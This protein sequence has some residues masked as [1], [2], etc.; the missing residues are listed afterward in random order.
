[1]FGMLIPLL[2]FYMAFEAYHTA[3]KRL[4]GEPVDEFSGLFPVG[5]E[6]LRAAARTDC[7]DRA[8][9]HFSAGHDGHVRLY[10]IVRYWPVFLILLGCY[11]LYLRLRGE[12]P[13]APRTGGVQ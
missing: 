13:V 8:G 5:R 3:S 2:F 6:N 12:E 7:A 9:R 4:R 10:Q 11:I 1:M